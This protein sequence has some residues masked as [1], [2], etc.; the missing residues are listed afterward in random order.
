MMGQHLNLTDKIPLLTPSIKDQH[1]LLYTQPPN[2]VN[3][4]PYKTKLS[5]SKAPPPNLY[6]TTQVMHERNIKQQH[7]MF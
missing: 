1:D 5:A 7:Q 6:I 3:I 2:R 4:S